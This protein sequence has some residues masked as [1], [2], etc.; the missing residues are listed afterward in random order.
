MGKIVNNNFSETLTKFS[1]FSE[2][3]CVIFINFGKVT[4]ALSGVIYFRSRFRN[5]ESN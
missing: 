3:S 5:F 4:N 1:L 2:L